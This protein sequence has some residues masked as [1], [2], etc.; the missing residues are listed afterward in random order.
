MI[1]NITILKQIPIYESVVNYWSKMAGDKLSRGSNKRINGPSIDISPPSGNV[2]LSQASVSLLRLILVVQSQP[3]V[4]GVRHPFLLQNSGSARSE[5]EEGQQDEEPPS[6][7]RAALL[8]DPGVVLPCKTNI[9]P[10][11]VGV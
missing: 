8:Q 4:S 6:F 7:H 1:R 10:H 2:S 3:R 9:S 11:V 5:A